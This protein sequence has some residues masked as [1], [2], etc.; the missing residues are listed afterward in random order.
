MHPDKELM[1]LIEEYMESS[2]NPDLQGYR[3]QT[4]S[5]DFA[6]KDRFLW[7]IK[8]IA[9]LGRLRGA[10]ILDVGCGCGWQAF[11]T[12]LL[13]DKNEVVGMDILP[14]MIQG[15]SECVAA[16]HKKGVKFSLTPICADICDSQLPLSSFD[17]IYSNEAIEHVHDMRIMLERCYTLLRPGG[18][19]ILLNDAN[20][21]N[22]KVHDQIVAMW[23]QRENSWEWSKYLRSIRPIEHKDARP[24]SVMRREI[25][26]AANPRLT[27][28]EVEM[29][30]ASTAG[31]LKPE[32]EK[33]ALNFRTG[34]PLAGRPEYDWCRNPETGEY[35]ERLFDPFAL[36][37]QMREAGFKTQVRHMFRKFPLSLINSIQIERVNRP[38][39]DLRPSFVLFGRKQD[40]R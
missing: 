32:I 34:V 18:T 8:Y 26:T 22:S 30:V 21:L 36:A 35:A 40:A 31:L 39:F 28:Q 5:R 2:D 7:T 16:M 12:S 9:N 17:S 11:A 13:D 27:P 37:T 15:M 1:K 24:F 14:S 6:G 20:M 19:L 33:I 29:V 23:E 4:Y 10:R 3:E 38:L 25:V